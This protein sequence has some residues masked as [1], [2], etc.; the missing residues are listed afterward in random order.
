[1][2]YWYVLLRRAVDGVRVWGS[3][4]ASFFLYLLRL[5][6]KPAHVALPPLL[7]QDEELKLRDGFAWIDS[8]SVPEDEDGS[9]SWLE[10]VRRRLQDQDGGFG[11]GPVGR[12]RRARHTAYVGELLISVRGPSSSLPGSKFDWEKHTL[13]A[14][15]TLGA[16]LVEYASSLDAATAVEL[17]KCLVVALEH[18]G[19]N[20]LLELWDD[21]HDGALGRFLSGMREACAETEDVPM[22][23]TVAGT[24]PA[25]TG[26]GW[27][28]RWRNSL[29]GTD[30]GGSMDD[31]EEGGGRYWLD[32]LLEMTQPG[33]FLMVSCATC[34]RAL[35]RGETPPFNPLKHFKPIVP[36]MVQTS[37]LGQTDVGKDGV[38]E[39]L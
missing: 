17:L 25:V 32:R 14:A 2:R 37:W 11:R 19:P 33:R 30:E 16:Q 22:P 3:T 13:W 26:S 28:E 29:L 18:I 9:G 31:E 34:R 10:T 4:A 8:R 15:D 27:P 38:I 35:Q 21:V 5:F 1:M 39:G 36:L 12:A 23:D 7:L 20:L 24:S 6:E